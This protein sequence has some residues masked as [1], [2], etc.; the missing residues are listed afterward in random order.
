MT[1]SKIISIVNRKGGVGKTTLA[2]GIADAFVSEHKAHVCIVDLDPQSSASQALLP[3]DEFEGRVRNDRNL[4]G[5][6]LS[7]LSGEDPD[8]HEYRRDMLH[9]IKARDEVD[10]RLYPNSQ[11]LWDLEERE[12]L[13]DGGARLANA[14]KRVLRQEA[15]EERIVIVD[16]PPGQSVSALAA[17]QGSDLVLCPITPDRLA[18][19]GKDVLTEYLKDYAPRVPRRFVVTRAT[20]RDRE[21]KGALE[22]LSKDPD[23]LQVISGD[24]SRSHPDVTRLSEQQVVRTRIGLDREKPLRRIYGSLCARELT[25]IVNALRRELEPHG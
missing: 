6:L 12:L 21:A 11:R 1:I 5:L 23:M 3:A 15:E 16:C 18:M 13:L 4:H 24:R 19:W 8:V 25:L 20:Y 17:I 22:K 14:I 2:M 10:M 9:F 7:R